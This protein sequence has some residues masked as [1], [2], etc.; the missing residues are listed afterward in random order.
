MQRTFAQC[1]HWDSLAAADVGFCSPQ[2]GSSRRFS[3]GTSDPSTHRGCES[4]LKKLP[5]LCTRKSGLAWGEPRIMIDSD[6]PHRL[7][8]V[9]AFDLAVF[10]WSHSRYCLVG[11]LFFLFSHILGI[12]IPIDSYFSE[13]WPNH[14]P[15]VI[16]GFLKMV[17]PP[18]T[19]GFNV[20]WSNF[21]WFGDSPDT[22]LQ[23]LS[24]DIL[25]YH[26]GKPPTII[27]WFTMF[28]RYQI[29]AGK[30]T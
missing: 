14:Q 17:D 11:V 5:F 21:S 4:L 23:R 26:S 7:G 20:K 9:V 22:N 28:H 12:I 19:M 1:A 13:G 2:A 3:D 18:S 16:W 6:R 30:L 8:L 27:P 10:V 25:G 29:P 24:W 15:V